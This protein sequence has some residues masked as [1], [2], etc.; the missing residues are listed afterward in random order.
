MFKGWWHLTPDE[1]RRQWTLEPFAAVG[2]LRFGMS[3]GEVADA[4]RAVAAEPE[5]YRRRSPAH[6]NVSTIVEGCGSVA[7]SC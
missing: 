7:G 3:L 2:P 1:E 4:M 6:S 5:R